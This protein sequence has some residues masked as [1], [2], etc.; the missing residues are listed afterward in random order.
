MNHVQTSEMTETDIR[1]TAHLRIKQSMEDSNFWAGP[2]INTA[3][4]V[5]TVFI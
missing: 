4:L 3:E 1:H 2:K 5:L